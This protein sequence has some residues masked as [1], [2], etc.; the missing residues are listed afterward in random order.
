MG[1]GASA[2]PV[3]EAQSTGAQTPRQILVGKKTPAAA[4]A[5]PV[6]TSSDND[7]LAEARKANVELNRTIEA[8]KKDVERFEDVT[9]ALCIASV[10][11]HLFLQIVAYVV[12]SVPYH[13]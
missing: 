10:S 12:T 4:D 11:A 1:C 2:Q 5:A 7:E 13:R 3:E 6:S 9:S 8:L